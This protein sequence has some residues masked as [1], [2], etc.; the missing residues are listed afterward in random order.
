MNRKGTFRTS[1][2]VLTDTNMVRSGGD[3]ISDQ[4][5]HKAAKQAEHTASVE[6]PLHKGQASQAVGYF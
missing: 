2:T 4:H 6:N 1:Y 3:A 5:K